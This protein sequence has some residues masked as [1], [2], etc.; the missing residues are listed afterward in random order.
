MRHRACRHVLL[1]F[2]GFVAAATETPQSVEAQQP[3]V[4]RDRIA[5]HWFADGMRF[6]YRVSLPHS[7]SE[8]VLVDPAAG[9]RQPAF[10]HQAVARRL[11]SIT[12]SEVSA[13]KLP[14]TSLKFSDDMT[15]VALQGRRE[16]WHLSLGDSSIVAV[17][18]P[19]ASKETPLFL[20]PR[21]SVN[22]GD[23]VQLDI[24]NQLTS[25][26]EIFWVDFQGSSQPYGVVQAQQQRQQHTFAGHVWQIKSNGQTIGYFQAVAGGNTVTINE[27]VRE[28]LLK[29][30]AEAA[31]VKNTPRKRSRIP[32]TAAP[33]ASWSAYVNDHDLWIRPLK[34]T[35]GEKPIQ[36]SEDGV[37]ENSFQKN[38][39][40]ARLVEM[41]YD[42]PKAAKETADVRWSPNSKYLVAFQTSAVAESRVHYIESAPKDSLQPQLRSYP[43]AKPGDDLPIPTPRLYRMEDRQEI[44]ISNELFANP[45]KLQFL[46]WADDNSR[47]WLLDN[48]RGHQRLRVLEVSAADGAVRAIVDES[49][50]TFIHYSTS[51][52]FE[53]EW[54]PNN[55]LLWASERSGWNHL[56]RY[57]TE[58]G[59]VLNAVTSGEW[60]VRRIERIDRNRGVIWFYAVG[61]VPDQ[62]PYHEHFCSVN[63][64]GSDLKVLTQGD[65]THE[66]TWSPNRQ[67]FLD[68]YSRVDLAPITELRRT[69]NGTLVT[70]LEEA[71][72]TEV[73]RARGSLPIRFAAVGR[74]GT[75]PIYGIMHL[76][77]NFDASRSYPVVENIYAGPHD[78]HVPKAFRSDYRHQR[79]IA[80]RGMV[81]VQIDGMGTAWRSK[82]FHDVCFKNLRDAGFPDRIAWMRAA[83]AEHPYLDVSRVGIYG[84]SAGG[85]NAMAALLW[86]GTFYKAAVADCG[87][88]DNRM[89]RL[90]WNE[91]WM[92]W[93]VD[94]FYAANSNTENASRLQGRLMLV[95][96]ELDRNVDPASTTQV[97]DALIRADK[98]F[99]FLPIP[100]AGHGACER[101][102]GSRR[103]ADFLAAAL[104]A[105]PKG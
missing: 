26:V 59:K 19:A 13:K 71:D 93:P 17:G 51:G 72:A 90:W 89:D 43:Y 85:Q 104:L 21:R 79:Q 39:S 68:R 4:Y 16:L 40:R 66:I 105:D 88:H 1:L 27:E 60:N 36:L 62:D 67:F 6:W 57:G 42:R 77:A 10:D 70:K 84:G 56:Y 33:N 98:D 28:Q 53:L 73:T 101:P 8:F 49:S 95:V 24:D 45:F 99:T 9:T 69:K 3:R 2:A 37:E 87:C 100:G 96:G 52:K 7:G 38:T 5:P 29:R 94:D 48:E 58:T 102:Y 81:V 31:A 92:G 75:T 61:I 64:D 14:F 78:H 41:A 35:G 44:A 20:K 83:A 15:T 82:K 25:D 34:D 63:I 23:D 54:L 50:D 46:K 18:S 86:H 12:Q 55:E 97:V 32:S 76:P 74:D 80:D 30:S 103:R 65:G 91:Q 47:F 22:R 11:S